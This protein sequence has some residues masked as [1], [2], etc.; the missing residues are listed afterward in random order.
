[1]PIQEQSHSLSQQTTLH[2][3]LEA[4]QLHSLEFL[5]ASI[6]ELEQKIAEEIQMNPI[7]EPIQPDAFNT[8]EQDLP[9]RLPASENDYD[10]SRDDFKDSLEKMLTDGSYDRMLQ[11]DIPSGGN[12]DAIRDAEDR[13]QY[14]F[15]SLESPGPGLQQYLLDQLRSTPCAKVIRR[16]A[17]EIIG[18]ID[19]TGYLRT[20]EGDIAQSTSCSLQVVAKALHLVQS[21]DPPGIGA[22]TPEECLLLQLKRKN[23]PVALYKKLLYD[24]GEDLMRNRM[25]KIAKDLGVDVDEVNDMLAVLR[26]LNPHPGSAFSGNTAPYIY[27]EGTVRKRDDGEYEVIANREHLPS[28]RISEKY[29]DMLTDPATPEE[30]RKY[31][32]EKILDGK[33]LEKSLDLRESTIMR[34]AQLLVAAQ[35][36]F[37]EKGPAALHPLTQKEIADK[38]DLHET[39]VSR[40]IA[41]KYLQTP[42]GLIPFRDFFAGGYESDDGEDIS[43]SGIKEIIKEAVADEDPASPLSDSKLEK[44]LKDRGYTVARRTI[45]KYREELGIPSSQGRKVYTT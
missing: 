22:R 44:I 3:A 30:T 20:A 1:M 42:R 12:A 32:K 27:P 8:P 38:M 23:I 39:T 11:P 10:E 40:A 17:A 7:L 28:F 6:M 26:K 33:Q 14:M 25:P 43:V 5:T 2:T 35:Y 9:E 16:A 15:D 41:N 13:R 18:S 21:F 4:R 45:A 29:L 37:L 19:E 24:C 36:D 31:L 34:I